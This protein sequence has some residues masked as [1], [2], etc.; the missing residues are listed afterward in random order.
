MNK[1]EKDLVPTRSLDRKIAAARD[2]A[3]REKPKAHSLYKD[4]ALVKGLTDYLVEPEK[5][6]E[7]KVLLVPM[8]QFE[9]FDA[10]W[11][12][13]RCPIIVEFEWCWDN[14]LERP[15]LYAW[16]KSKGGTQ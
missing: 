6:K 7:K 12:E 16:Y 1:E 9:A 15:K 14:K 3:E 8:V 4:G 2:R 11:W 10:T 5:E 13:K